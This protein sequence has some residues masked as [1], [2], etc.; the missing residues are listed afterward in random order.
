MINLLAAK[1]SHKIQSNFIP[2]KYIQGCFAEILVYI[3]SFIDASP[4]ISRKA[5]PLLGTFD[6]DQPTFFH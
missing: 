3:C 6:T 5:V 2:E 1:K 4:F